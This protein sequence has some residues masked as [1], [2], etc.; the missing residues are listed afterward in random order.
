MG[1]EKLDKDSLFKLFGFLSRSQLQNLKGTNK[2]LRKA[3]EEFILTSEKIEPSTFFYVGKPFN[4]PSEPFWQRKVNSHIPSF[5]FPRGFPEL[6][7]K[8]YKSD[9]KEVRLFKK[10]AD[11]YNYV[12]SLR[13][14]DLKLSVEK[15][16]WYNPPVI[17]VFE[18]N[19]SGKNVKEITFSSTGNK[20]HCLIADAK[21]VIPFRAYWN[22]F[23]FMEIREELLL[24]IDKEKEGC[25]TNKFCSII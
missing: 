11:A 22:T 5:P 16:G 13:H 2:P 17:P 10:Y 15:G 4:L 6:I 9:E 8:S 12:C 19:F 24:Q 3:I 18:V 25:Q 14:K 7:H 1:F 23:S 21:E 20:I